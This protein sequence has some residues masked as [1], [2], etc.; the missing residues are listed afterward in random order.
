MSGVRLGRIKKELERLRNDPPFGV[1]CWPK[2]GRLDCLEA[3]L[4]GAKDTP[5]DGGIFKLEIRVP[6]RYPFEPPQVQFITKIYHPNIDTAGRI[7]LDVLKSPPQGSWKPSQNI[8]TILT[9][10]QLLLSEPNPDDGLMAEISQEYKHNRPGF[11][12]TAKEW[13]K[14]YAKP[15][16][17]KASGSAKPNAETRTNSADMEKSVSNQKSGAIVVEESEHIKVSAQNEAASKSTDKVVPSD[18]EQCAHRNT[19]T[20]IAIDDQSSSSNLVSNIDSECTKV[21]EGRAIAAGRK[22]L[23]RKRKGPSLVTESALPTKKI[24]PNMRLT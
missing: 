9:S 5:Y 14:L 16:E 18:H 13:V 20:C 3:Q 6:D 4:M 17:P 23:S 15:D 2:D 8:S 10:I 19:T 21:S 24:H 1:S 12:R 11:L 22:G 7:C